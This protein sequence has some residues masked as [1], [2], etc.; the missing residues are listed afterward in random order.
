L[1]FEANS[2]AEEMAVARIHSNTT[3]EMDG[4]S[5]PAEHGY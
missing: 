3:Q 5:S 2:G 1:Y 4:E